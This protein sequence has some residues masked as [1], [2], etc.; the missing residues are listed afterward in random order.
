MELAEAGQEFIRAAE[1]L[2]EERIACAMPP[3]GIMVEVP[4]VAIVPEMFA[5]AAF[6]SIGSNDL[7]QYVTAVIARFFSGGGAE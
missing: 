5:G 6:F 4:A 2:Q 7:T 1:A 3:L